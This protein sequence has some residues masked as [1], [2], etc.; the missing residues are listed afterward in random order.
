MRWSGQVSKPAD[1]NS[2]LPKLTGN[3]T[4]FTFIFGLGSTL[5]ALAC[6]T[7]FH[8]G[9]SA[10][11]FAEKLYYVLLEIETPATI[12]IAAVFWAVLYPAAAANGNASALVN[13]VSLVEHAFNVPL[14]F[15]EFIMN[16]LLFRRAH[17]VFSLFWGAAY[18]IVTFIIQAV[19][20]GQ[21]LNETPPYAFLTASSALLSAW[22]VGLMLVLL[23]F[24]TC[25]YQ[26]NRLKVRH[27]AQDLKEE[28]VEMPVAKI[29]D[30][31]A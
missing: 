9:R 6:F 3:F 25:A 2:E 5:S 31:E 4:L 7:D 28:G 15:T 21:N 19:R 26:V 11:N 23:L 22:V 8:K 1:T 12:L 29:E 10:P 30:S 20:Q 17:L 27:A 13:F 18:L 14:I 24:F 16:G